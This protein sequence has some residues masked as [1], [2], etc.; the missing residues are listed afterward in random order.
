MRTA[1]ERIMER[2]R[3][4]VTPQ[5]LSAR[6]ASAA[7]VARSC[8]DGDADRAVAHGGRSETYELKAA[9]QGELLQAGAGHRSSA[10]VI[11]SS[12]KALNRGRTSGLRSHGN[13]R[14]RALTLIAP[15]LPFCQ[16]ELLPGRGL[17]LR[18]PLVDPTLGA[19]RQPPLAHLPDFG[20]ISSGAL[21]ECFED[22]GSPAANAAGHGPE[23]RDSA[24]REGSHPR[25]CAEDHYPRT[26]VT[27]PIT[28]CEQG[29]P[30]TG[31]AA[32]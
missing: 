25:Q 23:Q 17:A 13:G 11:A 24:Q 21:V 8:A 22:A 4:P 20:D 32:P 26:L 14:Y 15:G 16:Y 6:R 5:C 3:L 7:A 18:A 10:L 19:Q 29:L 28:V 30:A 31:L 2:L 1:V 27:E 9:L 12:R